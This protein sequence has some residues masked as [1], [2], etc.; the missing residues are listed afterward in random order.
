QEINV[1]HGIAVAG[2][3]GTS[4]VTVTNNTLR[5]NTSTSR[6]LNVEILNTGTLNVT[7]SGNSFSN[8]V[9]QGGGASLLRVNDPAGGGTM[10]V[11]QLTPSA[12]ANANELDDANGLSFAAGQVTVGGAPNFGQPLPTLP[13]VFLI[14]DPSTATP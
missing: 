14:A 6:P 4:N 2:V 11:T 7:I 1:Q 10:N 12:A 3:A 8:N 5:D 13:T 9:G